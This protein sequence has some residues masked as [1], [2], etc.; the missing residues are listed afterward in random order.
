MTREDI[1][2]MNAYW[3]ISEEISQGFPTTKNGGSI[4]ITWADGTKKSF[5]PFTEATCLDGWYD[6][7]LFVKVVTL[8]FNNQVASTDRIFSNVAKRI[9]SNAL[10]TKGCD[11]ELYER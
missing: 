10:E 11:W 4:V 1:K 7:E 3:S 8:D 6:V 2:K 9:I 5:Q